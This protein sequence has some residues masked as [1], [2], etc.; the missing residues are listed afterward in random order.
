MC[1]YMKGPERLVLVEMKK[2][3]ISEYNKT[4]GIKL[5]QRIC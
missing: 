3:K 2:I 1:E 5:G 4:P